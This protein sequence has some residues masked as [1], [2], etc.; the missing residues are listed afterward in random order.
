[1]LELLEYGK[2]VRY[3]IVNE[4]IEYLRTVLELLEYGRCLRY[5]IVNE[6]IEYL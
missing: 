1:M 3:F 6:N 4:Y 2:C 5:F